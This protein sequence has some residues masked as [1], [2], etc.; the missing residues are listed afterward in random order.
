MFKRIVN[1]VEVVAAACAV[2]FVILLFVDEAPGTKV[3]TS[4][5]S[6]YASGSVS[7]SGS[8]TTVSTAPALDGGALYARNCSGCHGSSGQGGV[9]P[10]LS[11]GRTKIQFPDARTQVLFV[12]N[13]SGRMP[14]FRNSLSQAEITAIVTYTRTL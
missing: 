6:P 1:I 12:S 4:A 13:G 5:P 8:A 9:G 2:V 3:A 10:K 7:G 14:P 11:G